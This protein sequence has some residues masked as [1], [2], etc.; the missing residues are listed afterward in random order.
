MSTLKPAP[1][2]P[3]NFGMG[4]Y[5]PTTAIVV[6]VLCAVVSCAN[7]QGAEQTASAPADLVTLKLDN[8]D[9]ASFD[10]RSPWAEGATWRIAPVEVRFSAIWDPR[11]FGTFGLAPKDIEKIRN[12]LAKLT[13]QTFAET[14]NALGAKSAGHA[15]SRK[16]LE[17]QIKIIDLY[18][19]APPRAEINPL[20]TY[21]YESGEMMLELEVRE[22]GTGRV[23]A[24][25]RDRYRDPRDTQLTLDNE[26]TQRAATRLALREWATRLH[27]LLRQA[28]LR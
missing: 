24:T 17:L 19:N 3:E 26:I 18:L 6:G 5:R 12:D 13:Q 20:Y 14:L 11:Q 4:L 27:S 1:T 15:D 23:L 21:V 16:I 2:C 25:L 28:G 7:V 22:A 9:Q 8:I 10:P